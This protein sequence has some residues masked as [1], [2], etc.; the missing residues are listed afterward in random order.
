MGGLGGVLPNVLFTFVRYALHI[1]YI[2]YFDSR[3]IDS[4]RTM[5]EEIAGLS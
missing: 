2:N 1:V 4:G 3:L 5:L